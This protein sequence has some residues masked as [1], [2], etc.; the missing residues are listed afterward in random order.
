MSQMS[1]KVAQLLV[2]NIQGDQ[3]IGHTKDVISSLRVAM[4]QMIQ[5]SDWLKDGK[6]LCPCMNELLAMTT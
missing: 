5:E 6:I 4:K 3:I 2:D 1:A